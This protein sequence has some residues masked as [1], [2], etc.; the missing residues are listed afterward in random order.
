MWYLFSYEHYK[1]LHLLIKQS[2]YPIRQLY[3]VLSDMDFW[4]YFTLPSISLLG[5]PLHMFLKDLSN[6]KE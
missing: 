1:H 2:S 3:Y 5:P 6:N 4:K